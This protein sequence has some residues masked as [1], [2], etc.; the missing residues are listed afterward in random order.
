MPTM[1]IYQ[2]LI[3]WNVNSSTMESLLN[4]LA[5]T[6]EKAVAIFFCIIQPVICE[7]TF[8]ISQFG[9]FVPGE[10]TRGNDR[11]VQSWSKARNCAKV[12]L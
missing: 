2:F 7:G 12:V 11:K 3:S 6:N 10:S 8:S 9:F 1:P 4:T 5:N